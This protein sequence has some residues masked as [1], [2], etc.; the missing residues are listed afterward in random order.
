MRSPADVQPQVTGATVNLATETALVRIT[1]ESVVTS[2]WEKMKRQL[3]EALAK[4]LTSCGFKSTLRGIALTN[5]VETDSRM[6][7]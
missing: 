7:M 4:H 3:G 5:W 6:N 1:S 2:G